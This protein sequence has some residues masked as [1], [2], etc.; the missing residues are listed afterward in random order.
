MGDISLDDL[1][2]QNDG[3]R[4]AGVLQQVGNGLV[5]GNRSIEGGVMFAASLFIQRALGKLFPPPPPAEAKQ[6]DNNA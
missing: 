1:D 5:T 4:L 2:F 3:K 6:E